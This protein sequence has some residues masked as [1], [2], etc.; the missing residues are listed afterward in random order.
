[1]NYNLR[2]AI[3]IGL[4]KEKIILKIRL[5]VIE[6]V[7]NTVNG[8][9]R[10]A[11]AISGGIDS[12]VCAFVLKNLGFKFDA[13]TVHFGTYDYN[14]KFDLI[15]ARRAAEFLG[16]NLHEVIVPVSQLDKDLDKI[17]KIA[18]SDS[19]NKIVSAAGWY[20]LGARMATD[21]I[22]ACVC[23]EMNDECYASYPTSA[24]WNYGNDEDYIKHRISLVKNS[25][26]GLNIYKRTMAHN[27]V[28]LL[29]PYMDERYVNFCLSIPAGYRKEKGKFKPLFR[30]AFEKD[31]PENLLWRE[32]QIQGVE[33]D[34]HLTEFKEHIKAQFKKNNT[35]KM[36]RL[37]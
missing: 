15:W 14:E 5:A 24:R 22:K 23:G 35:M 18:N 19:K 30:Y 29:I 31:I 6:A 1:M 17:I 33:I 11:M 36:K 9:H 21:G 13:Y 12:V 20:Y 34:G 2:T 26:K 27:G 8:K 37:I 10:L 7:R 32:K 16:V 3:N 28:E 4:S 25:E